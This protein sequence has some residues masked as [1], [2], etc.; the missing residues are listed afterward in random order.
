MYIEHSKEYLGLKGQY[1]NFRVTYS[2]GSLEYSCYYNLKNIDD[3][4]EVVFMALAMLNQP[5]DILVEGE[6]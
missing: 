5:E 2:N 1:H 6:E 3:I 4:N